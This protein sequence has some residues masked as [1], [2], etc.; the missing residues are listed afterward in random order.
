M[1]AQVATKK[2]VLWRGNSPDRA[3]VVRT[4]RPNHSKSGNE[5]AYHGQHAEVEKHEP[6][7]IMP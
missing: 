3:D 2:P 7:R 5:P 1:V 6:R 4:R